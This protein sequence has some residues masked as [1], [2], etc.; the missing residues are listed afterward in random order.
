MSL[1]SAFRNYWTAFAR[2][3]FVDLKDGQVN[4]RL[5]DRLE[6]GAFLPQNEALRLR[7]LEVAPALLVLFQA[8]AIGLIVRQRL[9][10]DQSPG[11]VVGAFVREKIAEQMAAAA[12]NDASPIEWRTP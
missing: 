4:H 9:E 10:L 6:E 3:L 8:R 11:D 12:R 2:E 5:I 7:P 1:A